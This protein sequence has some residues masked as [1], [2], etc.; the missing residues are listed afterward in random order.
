LHL[1]LYN[2]CARNH[3]NNGARLQFAFK[4]AD[5]PSNIISSARNAPSPARKAKQYLDCF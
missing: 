4:E 5:W 3:A 2:N 1:F